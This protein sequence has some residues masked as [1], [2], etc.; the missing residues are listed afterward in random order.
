MPRRRE[1]S[2]GRTGARG[3]LASTFMPLPL[4]DP[5]WDTLYGG[6]RVPY[7]PSSALQAIH[8]NGSTETAYAEL[9]QEL[10]HQGDIGDASYAAV[11]HLIEAIAEQRT[12]DWNPYAL[13]ATIEIARLNGNPPIP[14]WLEEEYANSIKSLADY[15]LRDL[16]ST[17]DALTIRC[18]LAAV[19]LSKGIRKLG[20]ILSH[21][22]DSEYDELTETYFG[23][24]F[25]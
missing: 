9:W 11:P 8:E 21:L 2:R 14:G 18:L 22:D 12:V 15:A 23:K 10:H 16:A 6:Y 25:H 17:N 1:K 7:N 3:K 4:H 24:E 20:A 5:K 13:I 19:A